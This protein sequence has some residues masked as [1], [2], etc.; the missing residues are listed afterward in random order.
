LRFLGIIL[1]VLRR[2]AFV[3]NVYITVQGIARK[4]TLKT[5][6]PITSNN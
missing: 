3:Y 2:E 6:V 1:K 5:L 4:R